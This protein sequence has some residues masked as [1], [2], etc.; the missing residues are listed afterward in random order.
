MQ[1][2]RP[3]LIAWQ[4]VGSLRFSGLVGSVPRYVDSKLAVMSAINDYNIPAKE[5]V[6]LLH[7]VLKEGALLFYFT[8]IMDKTAV[9]GEAF[10]LL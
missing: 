6:H 3:A 7:H 4:Y 2:H 10:S 1:K 8:N 9:I 5:R